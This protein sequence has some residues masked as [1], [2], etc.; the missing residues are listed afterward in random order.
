MTTHASAKNDRDRCFAAL[1]LGKGGITKVI[2]T[3]RADMIRRSGGVACFAELVDLER[4]AESVDGEKLE[5]YFSYAAADSNCEALLILGELLVDLRGTGKIL[6]DLPDLMM[7]AIRQR[8]L[9]WVW[10]K[11]FESWR[12][13][14]A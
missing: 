4:F 5:E 10:E 11:D 8:K 2:I 13:N 6:I 1:G 3:A 7:E 12:E 9:A 14:S